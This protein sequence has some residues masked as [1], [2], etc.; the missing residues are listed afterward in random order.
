MT[1]I[2]IACRHSL[3][4]GGARRAADFLVKDLEARLGLSG[5]IALWKRD[6]LHLSVCTGPA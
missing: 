1:T 4:R 5:L 2:D 3:P 6:T